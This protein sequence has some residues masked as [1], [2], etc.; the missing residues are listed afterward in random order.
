MDLVNGIP[1][2]LYGLWCRHGKR[3]MVPDPTDLSDYPLTLAADP[4]PCSEPDCTPER[5]EAEMEAEAEAWERDRWA[6]YWNM[7]T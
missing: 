6:E 7:T 3:L 2:D 5:L 4:W 1:R